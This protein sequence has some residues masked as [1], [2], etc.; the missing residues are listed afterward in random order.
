MN[1]TAK[2]EAIPNPAE[3]IVKGTYQ[4]GFPNATIYLKGF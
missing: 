1:E 2:G 3:K 4:T